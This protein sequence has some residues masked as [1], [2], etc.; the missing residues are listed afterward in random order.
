MASLWMRD[1]SEWA[2]AP[3]CGELTYALTHD[4]AA[5]VRI[6]KTKQIEAESAVLRPWQCGDQQKWVALGSSRSAG[7]YINSFAIS[8]PGIHVMK[9]RDEILLSDGRRLFFTTERLPR[10]E[11]FPGSDRPVNCARCKKPINKGMEAVCCP[12]PSCAAWHHNTEKL[13]C[14][15][16]SPQC[17]LCDQQTRLENAK[18]AWSPEEL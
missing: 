7:I 12:N 4:P 5:P 18:Y 2:L 9:D 1:Q 8:G 13:S 15:Q 11:P 10:I 6:Q 16:Y 17:A 14:W 3:L